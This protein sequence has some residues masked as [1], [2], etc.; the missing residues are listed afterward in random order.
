MIN[1]LIADDH[2]LIRSGL[3]ALLSDEEDMTVVGEA[4]NGT[5]VRS[6]LQELSPDVLLLDISMPGPSVASTVQFAQKVCPS[7]KILILTAYKGE[8]YMRD[9][10]KLGVHG[11]VL[12][13][14][15][16]ESLVRAIR[17]V[18]GG[19]AWLSHSVVEIIA[20]R[21]AGPI[22]PDRALTA[23]EQAVLALIAKGYPNGRIAQELGITEGTVK[24]HVVS[25]YI[26]L[27]I[28]SRAEAVVRAIEYMHSQPEEGTTG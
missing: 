11:Y 12:K 23:R 7:L 17:S 19:D 9:L 15:A 27:A 2:Y 13:D 5:E 4:T 1:I 21:P 20:D 6:R 18:A 25:L 24:N 28:H 16:P 3:R 26:K 14:E 22:Q 10:I 8:S